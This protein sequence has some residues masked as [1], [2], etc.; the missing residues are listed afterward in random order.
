MATL[1]GY[2]ADLE[3]VT[4]HGHS[5]QVLQHGRS[6]AETPN[7]GGNVSKRPRRSESPLLFGGAPDPSPSTIPDGLGIS[8]EIKKL[9][10]S[11]CRSI[12]KLETTIAK[13]EM[14]S[15]VLEQHRSNGTVPKD[16]MLPK[17]KSLF[18]DQQSKADEIL[19]SAMNSLLALRISE[20]SRKLSESV[21]QKASLERV[22]LKVLQ[23][24]R[25]AQLKLLPEEDA[26]SVAIINQRHSLNIR[27]FYSQLAIARENSFFRAKREADKKAKKQNTVTPM[28]TAPEARVV[29]VLD[30]RLRQLGLI[31]RRSRSDSPGS[32]GLRSSKSR[33][34]SQSSEVSSTS[35]RT[36]SGSSRSSSRS[37]RGRSAQF[38]RNKKSNADGKRKRKFVHFDK[39]VSKNGG[40]PT[41]SRPKNR[42][43]RGRGSR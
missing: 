13:L 42:R 38:K 23:D 21:T 7:I 36:G 6:V 8:Q 5:L 37:S 43:G 17:K 25:D 9:V 14:K 31:G 1:A 30:Q 29:D 4:V 35:T 18:E 11:T 2:S 24:S 34:R 19:Q 3:S 39:S 20:T 27:S 33:S 16:L 32:S 15:E 41:S 10:V 40:A 28:D 26:D 22:F 12:V